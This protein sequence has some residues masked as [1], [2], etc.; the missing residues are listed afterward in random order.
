[1]AELTQTSN[2]RWKPMLRGPEQ[3]AQFRAVAIGAVA[4]YLVY[5]A[6]DGLPKDIWYVLGGIAAVTLVVRRS[7][8]LPKNVSDI[9]KLLGL[10][11]ILAIAGGIVRGVHSMASDVAYAFPSPADA[12]VLCTY[13]VLATA[14]ILMVRRR[15]GR[16]TMDPVLDALVGCIAVAV[17]QMS[18]VIIP[19]L[20]NASA[21]KV[22]LVLNITYSAGSL[23]LVGLAIFALVAGGN[24][25]ASNRLLAAALFFT[26]LID[27]TTTLALAGAF[28]RSV[29]SIFVPL[30]LMFGTAGLMHPSI[31]EVTHRPSDATQLRILT[32]KR[33]GVLGL[34][35]ITSPMLLMIKLLG[36]NGPSAYYL[37]AAASLALTPL[38]TVRLGRL[39]RQNETMA[40]LEAS[41]RSVG[42]QLVT[43]ETTSDVLR[44][45]S[46]GT[47]EVLGRS[48][49]R[50]GLV[51]DPLGTPSYGTQAPPD[52]EQLLG[53]LA[54]FTAEHPSPTTGDL[55]NLDP[56]GDGS[57]HWSVGL[58]V[59]QG[60]IIAALLVAT[61]NPLDEYQTNGLIALCRESTIAFRAVEQTEQQV[62]LRSEERFGALIDNSSDIVAVL[63]DTMNVTYVSPVASRL[64]GYA[65]ND[66]ESGLVLDIIHPDD[67]D[68][69]SEV[70]RTIKDGEGRP[71]EIR[72]RHLSGT[73]SWFEVVGVDM[74]SDP[75]IHGVVINAREITDRKE[76]EEQL[77][78]SEARF[79]ALVQNS[80]DLVVVMDRS[81]FIRY[82]SPSIGEVA[83]LD[84]GE[85]LNM[86]FNDVF[87]DNTLDWDSP[88]IHSQSDHAA[89][90]VEFTFMSTSGEVH[91]IETT[92][93]D[94]CSEPAINGYVLNARDV[95]YRKKMEQQLRYQATHDE[96]T[97]LANRVHAVDDL[98]GMLERN[99]GSTTVAAILIDLDEF[100][101][102]NDSLGHDVGDELLIA[103]AERIKQTLS[104]GDVAARIGGDEFAII[105]ERSHGESQVMELAESLMADLA[106]PF[107]ID[108]RE[109][110][111][112]SSAGIV[113][114]HDRTSSGELMLRNADTAMYR[115]KQL[116]KRQITV[117][118]PYMHTASFDR[119][120]LRADLA[121]A[122]AHNQFVA[123]YQPV[124]NIDTRRIVG[125]EALIRWEHPQRGLLGPGLFI[126]LAEETGL[127]APMG[128]WILE[129]A[130]TDLAAWRSDF[131]SLVENFTMSVNLSAQ[132]LH[133]HDIIGKVTEILRHT[134]IP[135]ERLV[136]E[137]TESMLI[138]ETDKAG[139]TMR[140]LRELGARLSIDDFGTG[141]SS[142]GYMQQ[143][144]FDVLKIDKSFIDDIDQFT[145]QRI[146]SAVLA[147]AATLEVKTIAEGIEE[148]SQAEQVRALG[149]HLAQGYL[150]SRPVPAADFRELLERER[151]HTT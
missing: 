119:L 88:S 132:Q 36:P 32:R 122:V 136:L 33:I 22:G 76:A 67:R 141:Y 9:A 80:T 42:E 18:V 84:S 129:R 69:A 57:M 103:I 44:V 11:G 14:M 82:A 140:K 130:C 145:N 52:E 26:V 2:R 111:V 20:Q 15:V 24:R 125:A 41:L 102:I 70:F 134:G 144:D 7:R 39:V 28:H 96:L 139:D 8:S 79:K 78:V 45:I 149:C 115:A 135:A 47:A 112:T 150:Y 117:F 106:G 143:F 124:V 46:N 128:E 37:P 138:T 16:V 73:Y 64:L 27:A 127:I 110:S 3:N 31:V 86:R 87:V 83:G 40:T 50:G 25:A 93:L 72:L 85:V 113:F 147:L 137:V 81:G 23:L 75:N 100:K 92:V 97:G 116:G 51:L 95:T 151:A 107:I 123:F 89:N 126:P 108:G 48:F 68:A 30:G 131:G 59:E 60:T 13:L 34:A 43:A 148:E 5:L 121:R 94:L 109:I 54:A 19:H 120:E 58:V 146:V 99:S 90:L 21:T 105:V 114:D 142:L 1:M 101:D 35:L 133:H 118:E 77:R 38:V 6:T 61:E 29:Q 74:S 98:T 66:M 12:F 62:R 71:V 10:S 56:S 65:D 91:T 53:Q 55:W 104:F 49:I 4:W 17:V 63:N